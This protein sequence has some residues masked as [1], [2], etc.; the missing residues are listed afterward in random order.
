MDIDTISWVEYVK[1]IARKLKR[2]K[3]LK[4]KLSLLATLKIDI[5]I[6]FFIIRKLI[7][8]EKLS[9]WSAKVEICQQ[10]ADK[11][12]AKIDQMQVKEISSRMIHRLT[13]R[14]EISNDGLRIEGV[15]FNSR[16]E[17]NLIYL[18]L[19]KVI[20]IFN[21]ADKDLAC[22]TISKRSGKIKY[23]KKKTIRFAKDYS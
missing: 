17:S 13:Y 20:E 14:C 21:S 7:E 18:T 23:Y 22:I 19:P 2:Q 12:S 16:Q 4:E 11:T 8:D 15:Y 9:D 1:K 6:G 5:F 10:N 3:S